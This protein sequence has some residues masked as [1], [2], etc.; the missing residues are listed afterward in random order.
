MTDAALLTKITSFIPA[1]NTIIEVGAGSGN[2]TKYLAQ[3][4]RRVVAI[5]IDENLKKHLIQ[6]KQKQ[7]NV[8]I[9]ID[10]ILSLDLKEIIKK[11]L[12]YSNRIYI[13]S[14]LPYHITEPFIRKT[15]EL[16]VGMFLTVGK[17]FSYQ[18]LLTNP[19]NDFFSGNS[20]VVR[21]FFTVNKLLDIPRSA[22][23]P[24]PATE[25]AFLEFIPKKQ[26]FTLPD[27]IFRRL[28]LGQKHGGLMK[29]SLMESILAFEKNRGK[30]LTKNE[31][32]EVVASL[33]IAEEI[34]NKSFSQLNNTEIGLVA[35]SVDSLS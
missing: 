29:N 15:A 3:K 23:S 22:F 14:N 5:E 28:I 12:K 20:L 25:S 16:G 30:T 17:K 13:V 9:I 35:K 10:N 18:A 21:S 26:P 4:S 33:P 2:L 6:I 7:R 27:F 11:E 19:D 8:E 32:R 31:A 1:K 34:L 24:S